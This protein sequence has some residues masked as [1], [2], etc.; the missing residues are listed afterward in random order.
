MAE[1]IKINSDTVKFKYRVSGLLIHDGKLLTTD[2]DNSG[3]LC[4]PGGYVN[5][6]EDSENA[7][8][9]EM[10]EEVKYKVEVDHLVAVIEN[11]FINKKQTVIHEIALYYLLNLKEETQIEDYQFIEDDNGRQIKHDFKWIELENINN[12]DFRPSILKAKITKKD[13]TF[14]HIIYKEKRNS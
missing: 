5:L 3:F 14:E 8:M 6:G 13:M 9:R 12:V 11:F 10:Q 4:L 2:M 7:I 1:S